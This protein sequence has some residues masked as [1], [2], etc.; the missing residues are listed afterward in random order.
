MALLE[1]HDV[2]VTY[3][4]SEGPIPAVRGVSL[5]LDPG[6]TLGVAGESGC[7]KSTIASSVLRLLPKSAKDLLA[8]RS[9]LSSSIAAT[10]L[11]VVVAV[12]PSAET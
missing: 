11:L 6:E 1:M 4:T 7:G 8:Q 12:L 5:S 10:I 3:Q 2:S 9:P